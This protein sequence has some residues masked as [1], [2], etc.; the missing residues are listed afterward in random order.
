MYVYIS[1]PSLC[2]GKVIGTYV[3]IVSPRQT[4]LLHIC[5]CHSI[6]VPPLSFSSLPSFYPFLLTFHLTS[7]PPFLLPP[8]LLSSFPP[9]LLSSRL[10][11][12]RDSPTPNTPPLISLSY[13]LSQD[14]DT[15]SNSHTCACSTIALPS[16][17]WLKVLHYGEKEGRKEGMGGRHRYYTARL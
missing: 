7:L 8:S 16:R 3:P 9:S 13:N 11:Q 12:R 17:K 2:T 5:T 14:K 10:I 6:R 1:P 4:W 15:L